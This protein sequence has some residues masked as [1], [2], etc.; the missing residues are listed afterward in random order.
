MT[1]YFDD[2]IGSANNAHALRMVYEDLLGCFEAAN[3]SPNPYKVTPPATAIRAFNC[4]L[5]QGR[6]EVTP[7]REAEFYAEPRSPAAE[8]AFASYKARVA[9]FNI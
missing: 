7:E 2:F 5:K 3:L 8:L 9:Q 6:V 1:V 4:E